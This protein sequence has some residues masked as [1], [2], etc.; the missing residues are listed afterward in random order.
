MI[1]YNVWFSFKDGTDESVE[2]AK[3]NGFLGDLK[4]RHLLHDYTLLRHRAGAGTTRLAR[5]QASIRL[6]DDQFQSPFQHV[7]T[8]GV[9]SGAHGIMIENI[10]TFIVEIFEELVP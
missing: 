1:H 3:V 8:T 7:V 5:F 9:H 6:A 2:L 10:D 4:A